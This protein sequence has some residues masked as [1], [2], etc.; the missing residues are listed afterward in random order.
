MTIEDF[1]KR[2]III[3][4]V[5]TM[6]LPFPYMSLVA[7]ADVGTAMEDFWNGMGGVANVTGPT[8]FQG[9]SAGYY[10]LGNVYL[11]TPQ[12]RT[13]F[14]TL[15]LPSY[16]AGCGGID[17]FAG[18]FSFINSNELIAMMKAIANNAASFAFQVALETISPVI[19]EK[20]GELNDLAQKINSASIN[21]CETAQALV[22]S[23]WPRTD[24]SSKAICEA[25]GTNKGI[26]SD[27]AAARQG[28]GAKGQRASVLA[29]ATPEEREQIP[30]NKNLTWE[31]I[32][33]HP[34][35]S[36]DNDLAELFMTIAG[37][38]ILR[39]GASD[40]D[41]ASMDVYE[42]KIIDE[43]I[44]NALLDGGDVQ[45]HSCDEPSLCLNPARFGKTITIPASRAFRRR[46]D[47]LLTGM[48]TSVR[49]DTALTQ[50]MIDFLNL[51]TLPVYKFVN[52]HVAYSGGN[53]ISDLLQYSE[54]LA[55]DF[56][57]AFLD[58]AVEDVQD[59]ASYVQG[60]SSDVLEM[61]TDRLSE[62]RVNLTRHRTQSGQHLQIALDIVKRVQVLEAFLA[63]NLSSR[64][65]HSVT[66]SRRLISR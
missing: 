20:I 11:R 16:R 36:S 65:A 53:A 37:T 35:L 44:I 49:S 1:R 40:N 63:S 51:S 50:E 48:V 33:K 15:N 19:A 46:I 8:A 64:L 23:V 27:Y 2:M 62:S 32:K 66:Y 17:L 55:I 24:R 59:A 43:G 6:L 30:I 41:P 21:S 22:G 29:G 13:Q 9:Q 45:V 52:V 7:H 14:A 47:V 12:K 42:P 18:S 10:T 54:I 28:C 38:V 26:F 25:L 31:A 60:G 57:F 61:W 3:L 5:L 4:A 39:G 56:V 58:S 34:I